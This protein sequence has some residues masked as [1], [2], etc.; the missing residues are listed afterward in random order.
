MKDFFVKNLGLKLLSILFAIS[1]WLFVNLKATEE[2]DFQFPVRWKNLPSFLEITNPVSDFVRVRV[3]G[4][5]RILSDL[6]PKSDPV[7][8]DLTDGQVHLGQAPSGMVGLLPEDADVRSRSAAI[9]VPRRV[10]LN[11]LNR[12]DEHSA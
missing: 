6:N 12:L 5:R 4:P 10:R 7:V 3:T 9:A 11:E 2:R 8:L 1:L